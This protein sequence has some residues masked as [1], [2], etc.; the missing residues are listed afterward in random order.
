M[1]SDQDSELALA[2]D[3]GQ[4]LPN[5]HAGNRIETRGGLIQEKNLGAV[6]QPPRNFQP[7]PHSTGE[8][9]RLRRA[10]FGE[11]DQVQEF[12]DILPALGRRNVV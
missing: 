12:I 6:H 2:L 1:R 4:H 7:A 8:C 10:P 9:F 11:I 5:S 3:I